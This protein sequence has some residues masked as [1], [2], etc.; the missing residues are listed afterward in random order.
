MSVLHITKGITLLYYLVG[1]DLLQ[2]IF[3][4]SK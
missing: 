4:Y 2:L 1:T 3:I